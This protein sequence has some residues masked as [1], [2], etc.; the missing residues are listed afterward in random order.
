MCICLLKIVLSDDSLCQM[1]SCPS[2]L[3]L[4]CEEAHFHNQLS[5][6]T[7]FH[8]QGLLSTTV[9]DSNTLLVICSPRYLR[10]VGVVGG[11][12][13]TSVMEDFLLLIVPK[14]VVMTGGSRQLFGS[15]LNSGQ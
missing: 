10:G 8:H 11:V 2:V 14:G 5:S 3:F 4:F 12:V 15:V 9:K 7:P 1:C 13:V 6:L